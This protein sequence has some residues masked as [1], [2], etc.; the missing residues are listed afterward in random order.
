MEQITIDGKE[1]NYQITFKK[2]KNTYFYF[3]KPGYIQI[4]APLKQ[5][6]RK[7]IKFIKDNK[8][9]FIKKIEK[10]STSNY[11]NLSYYLFDNKFR[12]QKDSALSTLEIDYENRLI[13]EPDLPIDQLNFI[14]K[15]HEKKVLH[16]KLEEL[17]QKYIDNGLINIENISFKTRYMTSRFGSCN[18]SKS[19][20]NINLYL[21]NYDEKYL[22]YV[23][24]HEIS[25]LIYPNHSKN[26]YNLLSKLSKNYKQLRK[27][28]NNKF[29]YR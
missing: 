29:S 19:M 18:P 21:V 1:I 5:S 11:D 13:M 28:L 23:F 10:V 24:L 16:L 7:I 6:R 22:E 15:T 27:E 17:K 8:D 9:A 3:K 4:N 12:K 2:N 14:Y 20:V 26:F 25:H